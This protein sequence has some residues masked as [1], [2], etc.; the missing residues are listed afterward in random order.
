MLMLYAVAFFLACIFWACVIFGVRWWICWRQ[1]RDRLD[2]FEFLEQ[3]GQALERLEN[4]TGM[5]FSE[6][7]E[8]N[9][10]LMNET[11]SSHGG[12]QGNKRSHEH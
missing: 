11:H 9:E 1:E 10:R 5:P 12:D 4:W 7:R 3:R 6:A 8:N 2:R